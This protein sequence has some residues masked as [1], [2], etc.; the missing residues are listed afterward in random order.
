MVGDRPDD[1]AFDHRIFR[2]NFLL[3]VVGEQGGQSFVPNLETFRPGGRKHSFPF[4]ERFEL[5]RWPSFGCAHEPALRSSPQGLFGASLRRAREE[6][7]PW[8]LRILTPLTVVRFWPDF[9]GDFFT[10]FHG[11]RGVG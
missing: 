9:G 5:P 8:G 3:F 4:I 1:G 10:N 11:K 6:N 2:W 7:G